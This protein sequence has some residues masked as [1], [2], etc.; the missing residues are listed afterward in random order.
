MKP[1]SISQLIYG[2]DQICRFLLVFGRISINRLEQFFT[3]KSKK[4]NRDLFRVYQT[5]LGGVILNLN[6]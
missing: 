1:A 2:V 4:V 3:S 6:F 5:V